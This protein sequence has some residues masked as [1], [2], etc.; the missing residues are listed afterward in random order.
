MCYGVYKAQL[1]QR[2]TQ[3]LQ[4]WLTGINEG[5]VCA[6]SVKAPASLK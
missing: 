6:G 1:T 3:E 4:E 2:R 5:D